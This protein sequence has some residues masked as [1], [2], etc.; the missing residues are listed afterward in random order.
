M[1]RNPPYDHEKPVML[2]TFA[3]FAT[4]SGDKILVLKD[5]GM[6]S[7]RPFKITGSSSFFFFFFVIYT[8]RFPF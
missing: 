6:I 4:L 1:S 2:L 8:Y 5:N 3:F 7:R